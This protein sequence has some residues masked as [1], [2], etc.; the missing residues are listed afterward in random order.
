MKLLKQL[1]LEWLERRRLR[2]AVRYKARN[3]AIHRED[4]WRKTEFSR[5]NEW[6]D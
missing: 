2:A 1:W 4:F 5:R 6:V 3:L